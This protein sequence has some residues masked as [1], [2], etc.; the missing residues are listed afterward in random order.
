MNGS[1]LWLSLNGLSDLNFISFFTVI[2]I[3]EE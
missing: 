1:A 3:S 2:S